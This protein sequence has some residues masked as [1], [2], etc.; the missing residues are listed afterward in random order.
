MFDLTE[1][2]HHDFG[3]ICYGVNI[4]GETIKNGDYVVVYKIVDNDSGLE[5]VGGILSC[6]ID[7]RN[8]PNWFI[9]VDCLN[10]LCFNEDIYVLQESD[11]LVLR[12]SVLC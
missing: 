11:V 1:A 8:Q 10:E 7:R 9:K 6:Y 2:M 4:L 12:S 3:D 5:Y